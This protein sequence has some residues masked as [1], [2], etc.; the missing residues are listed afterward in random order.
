MVGI[1]KAEDVTAIF[2]GGGGSTVEFEEC[3]VQLFIGV[4]STGGGGG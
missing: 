2:V 4:F 1:T 3:I